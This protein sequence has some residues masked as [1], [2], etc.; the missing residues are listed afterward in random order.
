MPNEKCKH[1]RYTATSKMVIV[2][3][4]EL[5]TWQLIMKV[6]AFCALCHKPFLFRAHHGFSTR[7]PTISNDSQELRV[8]VDFPGEDDLMITQNPPD[9]T[10][11]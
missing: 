1:D 6:S 9:G 5:E 4:P 8:A 10:I 11:H 3:M 7:E 2:K